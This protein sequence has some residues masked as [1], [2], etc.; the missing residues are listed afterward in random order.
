MM[1]M[2]KTKGKEKE[3]KLRILIVSD[4]HGDAKLMERIAKTAENEKVGVVVIA[5]DLTEFDNYDKGMIKPFVERK[6]EVLFVTGNHDLTAG[7]VFAAKYKIRNLQF[8]P[9]KVKNVGFF[10]VG[11]ASVGPSFISE[12]EIK[13]YLSRGFA[14]IKDAEKKVLVTHMR[15]SGSL[16]EKALPRLRY[17]G[18]DAIRKAIKDFKPDVAVCGHIHEAEDLVEKMGKTIVIGTGTTAKIIEI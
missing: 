18:S 2:A 6:I 12:D 11:G 14:K 5:G 1:L 15:P 17:S 3:T 13:Y 4:V 8:Y 9:T 16:I 7:E 10:G